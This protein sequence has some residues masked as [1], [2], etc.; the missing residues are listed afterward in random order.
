MYAIKQSGKNDKLFSEN[1]VILK[2][3][4]KSVITEQ[5]FVNISFFFYKLKKIL[6][7]NFFSLCH[8]DST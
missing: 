8:G 1:L 4:P 5:I 3:F 6:I 2:I 7:T